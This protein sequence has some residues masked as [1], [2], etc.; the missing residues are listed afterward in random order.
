MIFL[1]L[2]VYARIDRTF[3]YA[4][5][6]HSEMFAF[7]VF[8]QLVSMARSWVRFIKWNKT[9]DLGVASAMVYQLNK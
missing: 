5:D 9:L 8:V 1:S 7:T 2:F 6:R 4:F 3:I